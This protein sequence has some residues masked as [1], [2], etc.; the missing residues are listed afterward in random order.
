MKWICFH[1]VP[2]VSGYQLSRE[3]GALTVGLDEI[4]EQAEYARFMSSNYQPHRL[5]LAIT[6]EQAL[7]ERWWRGTGADVVVMMGGGIRLSKY[8]ASVA[9]SG[10]KLVLRM[11]TDGICS[12]RQSFR[13][14]Y[15][16]QRVYYTDRFYG[17]HPRSAVL[18]GHVMASLS[19][20][21]KRTVSPAF[22]IRL[23]AAWDQASVVLVESPMALERLQAWAKSLRFERL[24][25][26]MHCVGP[27]IPIKPPAYLPPKQPL[28]ISVADWTRYQKDTGKLV[29]AL[30]IFLRNFP[31]Y[32]A[33]VIGRGVNIVASLF[34]KE[35]AQVQ[36]RLTIHGPM[37]SGELVE[38]Y[39]QS[40]I[41]FLSSRTEGFP[42]VA[43][44][45]ACM[46]CSSVGWGAIAA[47]DFFRRDGFGSVYQTRHPSNMA[48]ALGK[49]AQLWSSGAREPDS[50]SLRYRSLFLAPEVARR[51]KALV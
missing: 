51:V 12:P 46:G 14:S 19:I 20:V 35:P 9:K 25:L 16:A 47:F 40:R 28:I 26:K 34:S 41:H 6:P 3:L 2:H 30:S 1:T 43:A 4:G 13:R 21:S 39:G 27:S 45:A 11:D 38:Q 29:A 8:Y 15:L 18:F 44:E 32:R 42:N 10:A 7:D 50:R 33:L 17:K 37:S 24:T 36:A 23:L 31:D 22:D 49:E 5:T 48:L